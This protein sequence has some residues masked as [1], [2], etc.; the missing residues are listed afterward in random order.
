MRLFANL[1]LVL[2]LAISLI[3]PSLGHAHQAKRN[4]VHRH[5]D[6]ARRDPGELDTYKRQGGD[7]FTFFADGLGACGIFNQPTD[8]IVALNSA[9]FSQ[10]MCFVEITI[11]IGG[12]STQAQITDECPGCPPGGLDFSQGL[13]EFFADLSVG[14]L[15]GSWEAGGSSSS[16]STSPPPPPPPTTSTEPQYTPPPPPPTTSQQPT[17]TSSPSPTTT[18]SSSSSI[19]V[20]ASA[21]GSAPTQPS[22]NV[23]V[24]VGAVPGGSSS[25]L[26]DMNASLVYAG[27]LLESCKSQ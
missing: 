22:T 10:A 16:P 9:Q 5:S 1:A 12:L 11:T 17:S 7:R 23:T 21:S 25:V 15:Y 8:F 6:L 4:H 20:S 13:F 18:S 14:V 19:S 3:A 26:F 27:L 2:S 24:S